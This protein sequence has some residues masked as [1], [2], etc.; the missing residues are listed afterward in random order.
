MFA[1]NDGR[2]DA[3]T[4]CDVPSSSTSKLESFR[5]EIVA[6][7]AH[8]VSVYGVAVGYC[9]SASLL[10]IINDKWAIT[11]FPYPGALTALQYLTSA[12]GVLLCG[13]LKILDH[14]GLDL[15][16]MWK[17]LP[18]AIIFYLSLFTNSELPSPCQRRHIYSFP[19][20]CP[21]VRGGRRNTLLEAAV[22]VDPDLAFA[23]HDS[24]RQRY[25]CPHGL[26]V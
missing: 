19:I 6:N 4:S 2:K 13:C 8:Q 1:D 16:T 10:S 15:L 12:L 7:L 25:L 26:S 14:D 11:K 18:A 17:F 20:G 3:D 5:S 22:A 9:I 24:C 23:G 21:H